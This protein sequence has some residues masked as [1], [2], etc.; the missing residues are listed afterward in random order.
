MHMILLLRLLH[1]HAEREH[2]PAALRDSRGG[3]ESRELHAFLTTENHV[4]TIGK[5]RFTLWL[6]QT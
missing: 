3:K 5:W 6:C 1:R 2:L 4:K